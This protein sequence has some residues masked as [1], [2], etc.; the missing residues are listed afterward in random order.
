[1]TELSS[2]WLRA[3]RLRA[4]LL[5][6]DSTLK[7][8]RDREVSEDVRRWL[9]DVQASG[10]TCCLVSNGGPR[11]IAKIAASLELPYLATALKPFPFA[12]RRGLKRLNVDAEETAMVG[13]QVFADVWAGNWAGLTTILVD[14][15]H[16]EQESFYTRMKRP[17][18]RWWLRAIPFEDTS[19]TGD[20]DS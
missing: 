9:V 7:A 12:L 16:P 5:D 13:D 8:Y 4:L 19:S 17:L 20:A 10:T 1:M 6:V 15:I 2:A 18:E 11:R 14:P 3:R